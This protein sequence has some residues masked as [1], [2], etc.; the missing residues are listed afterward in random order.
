M[1]RFQ[2]NFTEEKYCGIWIL[3]G[4]VKTWIRCGIVR[5]HY[6]F[7]ML[8]RVEGYGERMLDMKLAILVGIVCKGSGMPNYNMH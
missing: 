4:F 8:L 5:K 7:E 3:Q 6:R 2:E 1:I